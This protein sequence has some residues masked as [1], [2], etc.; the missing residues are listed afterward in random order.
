MFVPNISPQQLIKNCAVHDEVLVNDVEQLPNWGEGVVTNQGLKIVRQQG[1]GC[2]VR[3]YI[4]PLFLTTVGMLLKFSGAT[5][6]PD[7]AA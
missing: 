6:C 4:L 7:H 2:T 3:W 1:L 5:P